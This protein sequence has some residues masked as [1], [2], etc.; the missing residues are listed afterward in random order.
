MRR[1]ILTM[2]L[3]LAAGAA[4]AALPP[5]TPAEAAAQ[6]AKKAAAD[7]Q[8]AK[9]KQALLA[10]MDMLAARWRSRAAA[11][12]W[13]LHAPTPVVAAAAPPATV[14]APAASAKPAN[15]EKKP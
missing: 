13:P 5:P 2:W 12:G 1:A 9:D 6:A 4:Q 10:T 11:N 3:A 8:A 14:P 15:P 7:A